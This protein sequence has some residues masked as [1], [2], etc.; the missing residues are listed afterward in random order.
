MIETDGLTFTP[1]IMAAGEH[2]EMWPLSRVNVPIQ[3]LRDASGVSPFLAWLSFFDR[4][5]EA[6]APSVAV[7]A[8]AVANARRQIAEA[9][10]AARLIVLPS[11][12][13]IR[14]ALCVA[15]LLHDGGR[16]VF[17]D[18]PTPP[19]S[20]TAFANVLDALAAAHATAGGTVLSALPVSAGA[21]VR[22]GDRCEHG[23]IKPGA[24]PA[25]PDGSGYRIGPLWT[26]TPAEIVAGVEAADP[27]LVKVCRSLVTSPRHV[28]DEVWVD[29]ARWSHLAAD[30][31]RL[32]MLSTLG[33]AKLR[34]V[35]LHADGDGRP[36]VRSNV[37]DGDVHVIHTRNCDV[38]S[39][40]HLTVVAGCENLRVMATGDATLIAA[41]GQEAA[42]EEFVR[43]MWLEE[44]PE[45]FAHRRERHGWGHESELFR[46]HDYRVRMVEVEPGGELTG[47]CGERAETWT[48]ARG[49][50]AFAWDD[51][52]C[53]RDPSRT[54]TI[55]ARSTFRCRN[56]SDERLVAIVVT[57]GHA[58]RRGIARV[59]APPLQQDP[60]ETPQGEADQKGEAETLVERLQRRRE[61]TPA[62]KDAGG[63][64]QRE[65]GRAP[66]GGRRH[67]AVED[68]QHEADRR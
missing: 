5:E 37:T 13:G 10:V 58:T 53:A 65:H 29:G 45:A 26:A 18:S 68:L 36:V 22:R 64:E 39:R 49:R 14:P 33:N 8:N 19:R 15:A 44:R 3:F 17:A 38:R 12:R 60:H 2:R 34:P 28:R 23:L 30:P 57:S 42:I 56:L 11:A 25:S 66:Q 54:L 43:E 52:E 55:P 35:A 31:R 1:V 20:D 47:E 61:E 41:P 40:D 62:E 16:L 59:E 27:D 21:D 51:G 4:I 67:H 9:G 24:A 50:A 46:A 32:A 63:G 48:L 6:E 7:T